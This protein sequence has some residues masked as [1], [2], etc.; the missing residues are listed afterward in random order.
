MKVN[1]IF[2]IETHVRVRITAFTPAN[3]RKEWNAML[4]IDADVAPTMTEAEQLEA[5]MTARTHLLSELEA[6]QLFGRL[7]VAEGVLDKPV[8]GFS[9]IGQNPLDGTAAAMWLWLSDTS[10]SAYEHTFGMN[11][12]AVTDNGTGALSSDS[13]TQSRAL[14]QH[15]ND[16]LES[17]GLNLADNCLR[18][19]FFVRDIDNNYHGLVVARRE[20]FADHGLTRDTHYIASTGING[21]PA[22]PEALV[23]MDT[24]TIKGIKPEQITYLKGSSHLNPTAEYGVTFE[25]ATR[26][27]YSD[28][29]HVLIS[30][31]ASID[32]KGQILFPEDAAAQAHRMLENI[33]VL[34]N[35]GGTSFNDLTHGIVYLRN[36][37]DYEAVKAVVDAQLPDLPKVY[38]LA[39]VCRPGWLVEMECIAIGKGEDGFLPF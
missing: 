15:Y 1:N 19:W 7:F 11:Y 30:G 26:I 29:S 37:S 14:L 32:N 3:G 38:V 21:N 36:A 10:Q 25:R 17:Q 33:G 4:T 5:L 27:A 35:E 22:L 31:T 39:P 18:T 24:Y 2:Y 34:L 28:R 13:E 6:V 12:T 16:D 23:Q 9:C 20:Y 8:N